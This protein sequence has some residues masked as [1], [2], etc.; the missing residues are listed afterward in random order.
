M[1]KVILPEHFAFLDKRVELV[2][3]DESNIALA[4]HTYNQSYQDWT[5]R[6]DT[7]L[8]SNLQKSTLLAKQC[9]KTNK[10]CLQTSKT[11]QAGHKRLV[12]ELSKTTVSNTELSSL[13]QIFVDLD[14]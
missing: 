5:T 14:T 13:H 10:I 11:T 7:W 12:T 4:W 3:T 8:Q 1:I 6:R 9:V 2:H